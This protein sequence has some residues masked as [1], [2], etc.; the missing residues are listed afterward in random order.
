MICSTPSVSSKG[1]EGDTRGYTVLGRTRHE[2]SHSKA[3]AI[4]HRHTPYKV[5]EEE[6]F[7]TFPIGGHYKCRIV[8]YPGG[9]TKWTDLNH[10]A[11]YVGVIL[12]A[13]SDPTGCT[14]SGWRAVTMSL[15]SVD[16]D[17]GGSPCTGCTTDFGVKPWDRDIREDCRVEEVLCV[18]MTVLLKKW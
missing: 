17:P 4:H 7:V 12:T 16:R 6:E 2:L 3:M 9:T 18:L 5:D 8:C 14:K 1:R 15:E 10:G 11:C 13:I